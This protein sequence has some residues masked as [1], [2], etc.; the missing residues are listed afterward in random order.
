M[1]P[2]SPDGSNA[3]HD[4]VADL[5][6]HRRMFSPVFGN[7]SF[8][9]TSAELLR[10]SGDTDVFSTSAAILQYGSIGSTLFTA[11]IL[12]SVVFIALLFVI[13][14]KVR[15]SD[16]KEAGT[17]YECGADQTTSRISPAV[18]AGFFRLL[19]IFLIFELEIFV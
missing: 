16:F 9:P 5:S 11:V 2:K 6:T 4:I 19:A 17:Q 15:W 1:L 3:V 7:T 14:S 12:L 8:P 13:S 10:G 18:L